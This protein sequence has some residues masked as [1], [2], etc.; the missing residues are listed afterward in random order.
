MQKHILNTDRRTFLIS[1]RYR[2]TNGKFMF[3]EAHELKYILETYDNPQ[4][5]IEF[6][7]EFNHTKSNFIKVSK[8]SIL[9]FCSWETETILY[10]ENH[11]YFK[12]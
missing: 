10:L 6:I 8:E 11:Y 5:G 1:L 12:K 7:K 9:K 3:Q 4:K 2:G